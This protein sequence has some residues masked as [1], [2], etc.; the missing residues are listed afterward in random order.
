M[1]KNIEEKVVAFL[2]QGNLLPSGTKVLLAV[3]G[4]ADSVGLVEILTRMKLIGRIN[5]DFH[6]AH[7]NH[8]LRG[9][10]AIEDEKFVKAMAQKHKLPLTI[11]RVDVKK[12]AQ[13]NRLSI[14]TAGRILRLEKLADIA[15][16]NGCDRVA[17]AHHKNDNAETIIHRIV[18]GTAFKGLA[19][20]RPKIVLNLSAGALAKADGI[21]FIRPLL[22]LSRSEIEDYLVSQ[23]IS[24][25][26]DHTNLDCRFTRNRIRHRLLPMLQSQS[27][28]DLAE[29]LFALSQKCLA[30][31]EKIEGQAKTALQDCTINQSQHLV[32]MDTEKFNDYPPLLRVE[33][34]QSALQQCGVGLQK[35]TTEHY[36]KTIK[37]LAQSQTGKILQLPNNTVI[38]KEQKSFSLGRPQICTKK[39]EPV[40]LKMPGSVCFGDWVIETQILPATRIDIENLKKSKNSLIEWFDLQQ[41][42]PPLIVRYRQKGDKFRPFGLGASKKVGKFITSAKID[43]NQRKTAFLLCDSEKV[44]WLVPIRR[45]G[46]AVITHKSKSLLQIKTRENRPKDV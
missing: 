11:E 40:E 10:K 17:A 34:I 21:I 18:R 45:S 19:G 46:E 30:F 16:E 39:S 7:I 12:H 6:I 38:K 35:I 9:A 29:L 4:G 33:I 36:N 15:K 32:S 3:S 1:P 44:L 41:I 42:K 20:I 28:D 13:K 31:S 25:Q 37:F 24:W 27:R 26:T 5:N 23:N 8:Q 2:K 14:E 22:C 43:S